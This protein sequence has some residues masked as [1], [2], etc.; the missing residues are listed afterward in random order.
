MSNTPALAP[1]ELLSRLAAFINAPDAKTLTVVKD[2]DQL[3]LNTWTV[4]LRSKQF[5]TALTAREA[6]LDR[7]SEHTD[8]ELTHGGW[9]DEEQLWKV[10]AVNGGRNDREWTLLGEG[11][12]PAEAILAALSGDDTSLVGGGDG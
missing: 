4:D 2:G 5:D 3:L 7:L 9:E 12:T 8:W 6:L 10:H 1:I 11:K